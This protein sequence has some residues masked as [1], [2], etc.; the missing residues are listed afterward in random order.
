MKKKYFITLLFLYSSLQAVA[1]KSIPREQ[2]NEYTMNNRIPVIPYYIDDS[3]KNE[4]Y[5]YSKRTV[6]KLIQKAKNREVNYYGKTD[7]WLYQ[8][9]DQVNPRINNTTVAIMGST[10]PWYESVVLSYNGH[11]Y[12]IEYNKITTD[13]PRLQLTT[14]KEFKKAPRK[15]DLIISISSFEHDG[16]GRYGDPLNPNGDLRAM[17]ECYSMLNDDGYL[18]L[19]VPVGKDC[20]A[21]NA[22]RIYGPLRL[23]LLLRGWKI[24]DVAGDF[25]KLFKLPLGDLQQ[26]VFLLQK[27]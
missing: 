26:P 14:V 2:F 3:Q 24:V 19:S 4:T 7:T 13:D 12:T 10:I 25:E 18:I 8:I 21:W 20:I 27:K 16:L 9:L 22:H 23:P 1:P 11:P 17:K 5:F 15:F 6:N